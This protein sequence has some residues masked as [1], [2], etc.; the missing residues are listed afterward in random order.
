MAWETLFT[1]TNL[2]ALLSWALLF[3]APRKPAVMSAVL[4]LGVALLC[5]AYAIMLGLL[6]SG[7]VDAGGPSGGMDFTTLAGV[8]A[9]FDSKGGAVIGW[10]HYLAFDLFIGLWI[11]RDADAKHIGR[12]WQSPVLA[13]TLL[14]GP[15]GL[16]LWLIIRE[17]RARAAARAR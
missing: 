2:W 11:A 6:M 14:V 10:T 7:S 12:L 4:F 13:L 3:F 8:M 5:L 16:L 1:L 17:P 15:V 9:L